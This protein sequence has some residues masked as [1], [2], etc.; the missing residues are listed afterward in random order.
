LRSLTQQSFNYLIAWCYGLVIRRRAGSVTTTHP[1]I[2]LGGFIAQTLAVKNSGLAHKLILVGTTPQGGEEHLLDVLRE[3]FSHKEAPDVRLPLFFTSSEA[4]QAA[5]RA[6]LKRASVRTV[7]R[8]RR[9]AR[10]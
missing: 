10:P 9:A 1:R 5:G 2:S 6:F 4:S 8:I 3:A 7:D